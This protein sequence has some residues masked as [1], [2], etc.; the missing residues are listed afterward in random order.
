MIPC[1]AVAK[2][3]TGHRE[4]LGSILRRVLVFFT[5]SIQC[6]LVSQCFI[7]NLINYT[8]GSYHLFWSSH[9]LFGVSHCLRLA[10]VKLIGHPQIFLILYYVGRLR[11]RK[12]CTR[13][14][15]DMYSFVSQSWCAFWQKNDMLLKW[16]ILKSTS[17]PKP[18]RKAYHL[19]DTTLLYDF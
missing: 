18:Q 14:Q 13:N 17:E 3:S 12:W 19:K 6:V 1:G 16:S 10:K 2:F 7:I 5:I 4:A 9:A 8:T 11:H 15:F